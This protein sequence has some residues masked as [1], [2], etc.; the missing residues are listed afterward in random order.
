MFHQMG[1][2]PAFASHCPKSL[3]FPQTC[4]SPGHSC[5]AGCLLNFLP[6]HL[7]FNFFF[8]F[9]SSSFSAPLSFSLLQTIYE[10]SPIRMEQCIRT[11]FQGMYKQNKKKKSY[12][13][14]MPSRGRK[15]QD[16]ATRGFKP[17]SFNLRAQ[18]D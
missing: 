15:D 4:L 14:H 18:D 11:A 6:P 17:S 10:N 3:Q 7:L 2:A 13:F 8:F 9:P 16:L 5:S 12:L 1:R